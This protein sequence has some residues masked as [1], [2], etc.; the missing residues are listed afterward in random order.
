MN[1]NHNMYIRKARGEDIDQIEN[2]YDRIHDEE[3][4]G[5]AVIGWIRDVYPIRKTAEDSLRRNDLFVMVDEE[6]IVATA[7][8]NQIQVPDYAYAKWKNEAAD[9][10]V[11]VLHT[12]IVDPLHKG[13][14]CGKAFVSFYED[15][16][17]SNECHELRMDTNARNER[18]RI[19]YK[20]LGYEEVDIVP[21]VFNGIP[22]VQLVCLEKNLKTEIAE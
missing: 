14:G 8:I 3:E 19:M 7:I 9:D 5:K 11:M 10:E 13:K 12:L 18:A 1:Y 20:K 6:E 4:R 16:A 17:L 21:C 22:D 15:Y 2:I